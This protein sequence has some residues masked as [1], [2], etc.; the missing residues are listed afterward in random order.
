MTLEKIMY[1]DTFECKAYFGLNYRGL[2]DSDY[3]TDWSD[4]EDWA[5]EKL[6]KGCSVIIN[7]EEDFGD[8]YSFRF[9]P[10]VAGDIADAQS[11]EDFFDNYLEE[12][13]KVNN[14]RKVNESA[15]N[16][17]IDKLLGITLNFIADFSGLGAMEEDWLLYIPKGKFKPDKFD[18]PEDYPD[19]NH[20]VGDGYYVT[21]WFSD[22]IKEQLEKK[23]VDLL[24][25]IVDYIDFYEED[26]EDY[27]KN[28][29]DVV[30]YL[31]G[32]AVAE[33]LSEDF[34][35]NVDDVDSSVEAVLDFLYTYDLH[36]LCDDG[37]FDSN[38]DEFNPDFVDQIRSYI[39]RKD[40]EL[41]YMLEDIID[42]LDSG[43]QYDGKIDDIIDD[44]KGLHVSDSPKAMAVKE[45]VNESYGS[46]FRKVINAYKDIMERSNISNY[47][48]NDY[49]CPPYGG[50][51]F[52]LEWDGD[53]SEDKVI[54]ALEN[55]FYGV[56]ANE[57]FGRDWDH[58]VMVFVDEKACNES[59]STEPLKE[60][61]RDIDLNEYKDTII[62][63]LAL[64]KEYS[65]VQGP[66]MTDINHLYNLLD[67]GEYAKRIDKNVDDW[68]D[69]DYDNYNDYELDKKEEEIDDLYDEYGRLRNESVQNESKKKDTPKE[70]KCDED[71]ECDIDNPDDEM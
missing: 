7:G 71:E 58:Y 65:K 47:S 13:K 4:A 18:N 24:D 46:A 51:R 17:D 10:D 53:L 54:N 2:E 28:I 31:G 15:D 39:E 21:Q 27:D 69:N 49:S 63:A 36:T 52:Q 40:Y 29:N 8:R 26:E 56:R 25:Q 50:I 1:C 11:I 64:A 5:W 61:Y 22:S 48:Y 33:S 66:I 59:L 3:F 57:G 12:S 67:K 34:R 68:D 23:D 43:E 42:T 30:K 60:A 45:S 14:G 55:R 35:T 70:A 32:N 20:P 41:V 38:T 44:I 9:S 19:L 37:V 62:G 6:Q 16:N